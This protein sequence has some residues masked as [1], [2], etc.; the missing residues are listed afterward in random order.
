MDV[1]RHAAPHVGTCVAVLS[2]WNNDTHSF[3]TKETP[4]NQRVS[5]CAKLVIFAHVST[6]TRELR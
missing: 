2:S 6:V 4:W 5:F 3:R 1:C